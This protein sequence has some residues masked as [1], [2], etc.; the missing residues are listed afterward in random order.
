ML[1]FPG[2]FPTISLVQ[3]EVG[4]TFYALRKILSELKISLKT[5]QYEKKNADVNEGT[6]EASKSVVPELLSMDVKLNDATAMEINSLKQKPPLTFNKISGIDLPV[7]Q[8]QTSSHSMKKGSVA[9]SFSDGSLLPILSEKLYGENIANTAHEEDCF[10][11]PTCPKG[12]SGTNLFDNQGKPSLQSSNS[13]RESEIASEKV[14]NNAYD[15]GYSSFAHSS[16]LFS[17]N[18]ELKNLELD[19]V[20]GGIFI[21]ASTDMDE[22]AVVN[23]TNKDLN[24]S[25]ITLKNL[26]LN[27]LGGRLRVAASKDLDEITVENNAK[28]E[29]D[30]SAS[31]SN[32][33]E[34]FAS[35]NPKKL[36]SERSTEMGSTWHARVVALFPK[37]EN[38]QEER[39][40][41]ISENMSLAGRSAARADTN[42]E[43]KNLELDK[44]REGIPV[45][46]STDMDAL[47]V[48]NNTNKEANYSTITLKTLETDRSGGLRAATSID[49]DEITVK[50]NANKEANFFAITSKSR[51]FFPSSTSKKLVTE[52]SKEVGST[53][54]AQGVTLSS[55]IGNKQEERESDVSENTHSL[56]RSAARADTN[57]Q[58]RILQQTKQPGQDQS[59]RRA[60]SLSTIFSQKDSD[61]ER[62]D[63]SDFA[64]LDYPEPNIGDGPV[65]P[66]ANIRLDMLG[67]PEKPK[68]IQRLLVMFLPRSATAHDLRMVFGDCGEV[69]KVNIIR[70]RREENKF[71]YASI[72]FKTE[73]ALQKALMKKDII[74]SG[75]DV[76]VKAASSSTQNLC[77]DSAPMVVE[78]IPEPLTEIKFPRCTVMIKDLPQGISFKHLKHALAFFGNISRFVMGSLNSTVYVEFE[79]DDAKER[80]LMAHW[81]C[82]G[83]KQLQIRRVETS[84]T[85]VVR[86]SNLSSE[87]GDAKILDVCESFGRVNRVDRRDKDIVDVHFRQTELGSMLNILD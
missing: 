51:E 84:R 44:V 40:T 10:I 58:T 36:V 70:S 86:I 6:L 1:Q 47:I 62:E 68:N 46:A 20:R 76:V 60:L 21:A 33:R 2:K 56:G 83:G 74:V 42:A 11:T 41:D 64:A 27:K 72:I 63:D 3:K 38:K 82:I 32:I 23:N 37:V 16:G 78:N 7:N 4:G 71:N 31:T 66:R 5:S 67:L 24:C 85:T 14:E 9:Q 34:L 81:I 18:I 12:L 75:G 29:A 57:I 59:N 39:G 50:N 8:K 17:T 45:A 35:S 55:K 73:E 53:W 13:K 69:L 15:E 28:L 52:Q 61:D 22:T 54:H 26:E 25:A 65:I 77:Q 19:K 79:T 30:S 49:L 87:T 43:L 48:E 80:A